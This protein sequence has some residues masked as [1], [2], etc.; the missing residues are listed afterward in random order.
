MNKDQIH[1]HLFKIL[2]RKPSDYSDYGGEIKR[3]EKESETYP[4]CSCGCKYF[5]PLEGNLGYDWG[6]CA[7]PDS[8]RVGLLTWEHQAGFD[9]FVEEDNEHSST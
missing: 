2:I 7:N 9:C 5:V 8:K 4:D 1:D 6:V 3:W